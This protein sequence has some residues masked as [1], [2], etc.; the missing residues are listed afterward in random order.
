M[1]QPRFAG[2]TEVDL[3]RHH[4]LGGSFNHTVQFYEDDAYLATAVVEFLSEG[5]KAGQPL[6]VVATKPHREAFLAGLSATGIGAADVLQGLTWLDAADTLAT[7]MNGTVPDEQRFKASLGSVL[8]GAVH[9]NRRTALRAYGEMVDVLWKEGNAAGAIRLEELWNELADHYSLSL[10]CGYSMDNFHQESH[11]P[12]FQRICQHH[13]HVVPTE[14]YTSVDDAQRLVEVSL[15]QQRA[16]ALQAEV[17]HRQQLEQALREA[18]VRSRKAERDLKDFVENAV[19]G[20][21]WVDQDGVILWAN[22]AELNLLGYERDE[23]VGHRIADFHVDPPVI[24]D[25]M[26]RLSQHQTLRDYEARLRCKDGSIKYVQIQSNVR[27]DDEQFVHT[28][29]FTRDISD[30]KR[31]DD[32]ALRLASIVTSTDDAIVSKDLTGIITSW[33]PAAERMFGYTAEEAIGRSIRTII[34]AERRDEEDQVISR[35]VRGE[36]VDHFETVRQRKDGSF[37]PISLT[38]SPVSNSRGEIVGASKIARDISRRQELEA[39]RTRLF[40]QEQSARQEAETANR[41]KDE[42][43]A[44]LS[45]ELRNPLNAILGWTQIATGSETAAATTQRALEVIGRNAAAQLRL[46]DDLLDVSRSMNGKLQLT[47]EP[48]D[49]SAVVKGVIES[50][51]PNADAKAITLNLLVEGVP[52][53]VFGDDARLQQVIGNLMSNALKFTPTGGRIEIR[54]ER[55]AS[56]ARISVTDTGQGISADFL[57]H[58]FERFRQADAASTRK[59]G[60]LGLGLAVVRYLVE[61]HGGTVAADS[62]G[63]GCGATFT[64]TLPTLGS[65][66]VLANTA[67]KRSRPD[68]LKGVRVLIVDDDADARDVMHYLLEAAEAK[69][70]VAASVPAAESLIGT[71][72]FDVLLTDLAMPGQ[73]GYVLIRAIRQQ[74]AAALRTMCAVAVSA[75]AGEAQRAK[76]LAAGF[77][78]Y[79]VKPV[80]ADSLPRIVSALLARRKDAE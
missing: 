46:I 67:K 58:V 31:A 69:V 9:G 54:L 16:Q 74:S 40:E 5:L 57:P 21:H 2:T 42:F 19:E 73:D 38:V 6:I 55:V 26:E 3:V 39:E 59:H 80:A 29:C 10:L 18:L 64:I 1:T 72:P 22:Q 23:Y 32:A 79:I 8:D 50:T 56:H 33:N 49:L 75:Y 65:V 71:T 28:R 44:M 20:M 35:I 30:R 24:A 78:D 51:R 48:I 27:W 7:F 25:I 52:V 70:T 68:A 11:A 45:H 37:I 66:S 12:D 34:P 76:A 41:L 43:L 15:L 62:A 61:A 14:R 36:T 4:S 63:D 53:P 47:R 17:A 77:D 60:G 13:R